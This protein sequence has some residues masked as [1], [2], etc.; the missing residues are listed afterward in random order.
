MK[1]VEAK[2]IPLGKDV[3]TNDLEEIK[4]L[5]DLLVSNFKRFPTALGLAAVQLGIP[6][7]VCV[8]KH[9]GAAVCLINAFYQGI[10]T[11]GYNDEGCLS[12]PDEIWR[13]KRQDKIWL[14][15]YI[16]V[17][18]SNQVMSV[19]KYFDKDTVHFNGAIADVIQH[20]IDHQDQV[21]ISDIGERLK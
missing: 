6:A 12:L 20:E 9:Q 8:V 11:F 18:Q 19:E 16:Y 2:D 3:N 15:G 4:R 7:K 14:K 1:L 10:S 13:V 17:P 21:L 5:H